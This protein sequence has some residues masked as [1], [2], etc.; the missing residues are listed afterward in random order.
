MMGII[1]IILLG[2]IKIEQ[3]DWV[4]GGGILGPVSEWEKNFYITNNV[5]YN[6]A[7]Q[8]SPIASSWDYGDWIRHPIDGGDIYQHA[9]WPADFDLDGDIDFAGW[10]GGEN[11]IVFYENDGNNNFTPVQTY[12]GPGPGNWGF[13]YGADLDNDGDIDL[14]VCSSQLRTDR[15]VNWYRNEGNFV[16]QTNSI[17]TTCTF[18]PFG[19]DI[20]GDGDIDLVLTDG[21]DPP[22]EIWQN[23][24]GS[25]TLRQTISDGGWRAKIEDV[26]GDG[27][28]DLIYGRPEDTGGRV[29]ICLNDGNGNFG[30]PQTVGPS[31]PVDALWLRDVDNDGDLDIIC[32]AWEPQAHQ[33]WWLENSGD[34]INYTYHVVCDTS[35]STYFF[36]DGGFCE[37][38]DLDGKADVVSGAAA[39]AWF[40]Q[41]NYDDFIPYE[42]EQP[43]S[44]GYTHWVYP[45]KLKG[46]GCFEST[47]VDILACWSEESDRF[48][49]YENNI[50]K[51]FGNGWLESSVLKGCST[52]SLTKWLYFGWEVCCPFDSAIIFQI[53]GANG[54]DSIP[55]APWSE[56]IIITPSNEIDSVSVFIPGIV[57][58]GDNMFQYRVKFD[59]KEDAGIVYK[60]WVTYECD[61][62]PTYVEE[63]ERKIK[64][65]I[66]VLGERVLYSIEEKKEIELSLYDIS[67]RLIEILD[68]GIRYGSYCIELPPLRKGIYFVTIRGEKIKEGKKI[69]I[70]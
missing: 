61:T 68:K 13:I 30:S 2:V 50:V 62:F 1:L 70:F 26:D 55:I 51:E 33:V 9:I 35:S 25:F 49:W 6:V 41:Q 40:K 56:N 37:D 59:G 8:L 36:G 43:V 29:R 5:T 24:G 7:G 4:S 38:I 44:N 67:G 45:I 32:G 15:G 17:S 60:V 48:I 54:I 64:D 58:T 53:R 14:V 3:D 10:K 63:R 27:D 11:N 42:L 66:T 57:D 16:F 39:L 19:G 69:V 23:N 46:K 31:C 12:A 52:D 65:R 21:W 47:N 28:N 22:I 20:D 34:G 18:F